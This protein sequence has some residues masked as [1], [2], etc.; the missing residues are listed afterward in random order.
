[1]LYIWLYCKFSSGNISHQ[2]SSPGNATELY[3]TQ[4]AIWQDYSKSVDLQ[5]T[6]HNTQKRECQQ[7]ICLVLVYVGSVV[8]SHQQPT[9]NE[10][11]Q[12]CPHSHISH[13]FIPLQNYCFVASRVSTLL[14]KNIKSAFRI[15]NFEENC[16]FLSKCIL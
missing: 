13:V 3:L 7:A 12:Y 6:T 15:T 1:M 11:H 14:Y 10:Y 5:Y 16:L 4:R 8:Y 2:L 9:V